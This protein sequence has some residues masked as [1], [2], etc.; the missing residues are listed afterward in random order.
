MSTIPKPRPKFLGPCEQHPIEHAEDTVD[1]PREDE[2][3]GATPHLASED[4]DRRPEEPS[5][6]TSG[7]T[8]LG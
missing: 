7:I 4:L 6:D 1:E 3:I 2:L 8:D 5:E